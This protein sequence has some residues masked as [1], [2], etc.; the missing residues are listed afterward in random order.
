LKKVD[1]NF[2]WLAIRRCS[3]RPASQYNPRH[4][5]AVKAFS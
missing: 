2:R 3:P 1:E 4:R 5:V